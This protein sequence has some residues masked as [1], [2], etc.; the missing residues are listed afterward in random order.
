MN[1]DLDSVESLEAKETPGK[2]LA[3]PRLV[4]RIITG[5]V[6]IVA[7]I[8]GTIGSIMIGAVE[9]SFTDIGRVLF[10]EM[11]GANYFIIWD[12][13]LP[14]IIVGAMVGINLAISGAI[15]QCVLK[16][17]LADPGIIG[18]TAGAG[19]AAMIVMILLP[20][21]TSLVPLAAFVGALAASILVYSISWQGGLNPLRLILAGVALAA[22]FGAG[23]SSLMVFY[24]DRVQGTINWM[25][26]GFL[27]RSWGHVEMIMPY[28]ILGLAVVFVGYKYLNILMLGDEVAR[29]LGLRVEPVRLAFIAIAA[30]LAASAVSVAGLLGFVGLITPHAVRLVV[31]SDHK[32]LLPF[33]ALFGA[34]LVIFA[35]TTARTIFSPVE[36]PVGVFMAFLGAPFFIYLLRIGMKR[37]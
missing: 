33:S 35:D 22:F 27:G 20:A 16:N 12:I 29:G 23:I 32:F 8:V 10:G 3:D 7:L 25:V 31:G 13:R 37:M 21:A 24:S 28:T 34:V 18:V 30:F 1:A 5:V 14:R 6:G 15:L 36:I 2:E 11:T 19:L 26:G 9:I 4:K 17:P